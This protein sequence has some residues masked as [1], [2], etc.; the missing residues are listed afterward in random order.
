MPLKN[1]DKIEFSFSGLKT[2]LL[3]QVKKF[4]S[5]AECRGSEIPI[6]DLCAS[7]QKAVTE[8]LISKINLAVKMTGIKKVSA[9]GGVSANGSLRNALQNNKNFRA[10]L[11]ALKRCTDNAVMV[12]MAGHDNFM[13]GKNIS[14]EVIPDPSLHDF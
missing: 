3:W 12:A 4:E 6:E 11:P 13:R 2:A 9:S 10:W 14:G 5:E 8:A 1:T 7:F